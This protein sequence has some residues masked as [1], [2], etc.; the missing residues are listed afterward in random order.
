MMS[1]ALR[2]VCVAIY[3]RITD[4][5]LIYKLLVSSRGYGWRIVLPFGRTRLAVK[6]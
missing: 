5:M 2:N 3:Q 6:T 4:R 1:G